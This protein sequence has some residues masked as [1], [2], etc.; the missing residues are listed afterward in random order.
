MRTLARMGGTDWVAIPLI[1]VGLAVGAS[2]GKMW[3]VA[4][5]LG[6]CVVFGIALA[7]RRRRQR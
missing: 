1:A 5:E 3:V 2:T 6:A 4:L 7:R